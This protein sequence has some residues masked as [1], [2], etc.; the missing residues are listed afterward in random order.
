MDTKAKEELGTI[1]REGAKTYKYVQFSG[2]GAGAVVAVVAGDIVVYDNYSS[3]LVHADVSAAQTTKA[4]GAGQAQAAWD[5]VQA[6]ASDRF[7]WVLVKGASAIIPTD[8]AGAIATGDAVFANV[9]K[10]MTLATA[11]DDPVCAYMLDITGSA[12]LAIMDCVI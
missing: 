2:V 8:V 12:M 4:I 7:G 10:T 6:A 11:A 5:G 1:R 9:D 3:N